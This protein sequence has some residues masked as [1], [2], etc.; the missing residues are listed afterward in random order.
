LLAIIV[1]L[2]LPS[3]I[4]NRALLAWTALGAAFGP[5]VMLR[6]GGVE[7]QAKGIF[8]GMVTGFLWAVFFHFNP[9]DFVQ[10]YIS[11]NVPATVFERI[12][13]FIAGLLVLLCFRKKRYE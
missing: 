2:E 4:F 8:F 13:S 7:L 10:S 1:A 3:S 12:F 5:V 6:L 11:A 9:G